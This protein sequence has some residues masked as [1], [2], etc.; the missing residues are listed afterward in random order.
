MTW[1]FVT[2]RRAGVELHLAEG[3]TALS[4]DALRAQLDGDE[5]M[6]AL[7]HVVGPLDGRELWEAAGIVPDRVSAPVL[8]WLGGWSR[9]SPSGRGGERA[10]PAARRPGDVRRAPWVGDGDGG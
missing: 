5:V 9:R 7:R 8:T 1:W 10:V 2:E 6:L 4:A 3:G